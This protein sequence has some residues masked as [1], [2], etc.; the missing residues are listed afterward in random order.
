MG[1][2]ELIM[3]VD[4]DLVIYD[5]LIQMHSVNENDNILMKEALRILRRLTVVKGRDGRTCR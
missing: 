2:Q 3:E 4:P 5:T 1:L